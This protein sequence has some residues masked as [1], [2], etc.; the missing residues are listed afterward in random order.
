MSEF[1]EGKT[2]EIQISE[3]GLA[4]ITIIRYVG[5]FLWTRGN[6]GTL[7]FTSNQLLELKSGFISIII[8]VFVF[9]LVP[10]H[11]QFWNFRHHRLNKIFKNLDSI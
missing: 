8:M 3:V 7:V 9:K 11:H 2:F 1:G 4:V 5:I 10:E 6:T